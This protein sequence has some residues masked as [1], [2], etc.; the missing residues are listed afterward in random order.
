MAVCLHEDRQL[1]RDFIKWAGVR[2]HPKINELIVTEQSLPGELIETGED[3]ANERKGLPDIIV[4]DDESWCLLVESKIQAGLTQDQLIRHQQTV[5]KRGFGHVYVLAM[6]KQGAKIHPNTINRTWCGLYE[7]LGKNNQ[8]SP[9]AERLRD[10]LRVAEVRMAR[11][12]YLTE[13][14]LTMFDGFPFSTNPYTYGEAK[15]LLKL[16]MTELRKNNSLK[17]IG[18][19]PEAPGR[20]KITGKSGTGIWDFLSLK[21]RP[22]DGAFTNYPHLTLGVREQGLWVSVTIPNGVVSKVSSRLAK[23]ELAKL[24]N[25]HRDILRKSRPLL[26]HG[27]R[28]DA[29]ALQRHYRSQSAPATTDAVLRFN[30]ET[31]LASSGNRVKQQTQWASTLLEV[32]K[33]KQSNIQIGYEV[34]IPWEVKGL[35]TR[36]SLNLIAEAWCALEPLLRL[37][38]SK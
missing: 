36:E 29:Y 37:L 19:D 25:L 22:R 24:L 11:D 31:S 14:T 5:S 12:E 30:L 33:N 4:H 26:K 35:D 38:C 17:R 28:V 27:A 16:A 1:L 23:L 2:S 32:L 8:H 18:M 7:W 3:E 13:G 21:G 9:W 6:T 10:Y 34:H 20:G 15:R